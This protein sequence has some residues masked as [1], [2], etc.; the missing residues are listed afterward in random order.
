MSESKAMRAQILDAALA[1]V[2]TRGYDG[3]S[4]ADVA[5]A[6]GIRKPSVH[7]HFPTKGDLALALVER[8]RDDCRALMDA[9]PPG[10]TVRDRLEAYADLFRA[11]LRDGRMCLCGM[12]AAGFATQ[13]EPLRLAVA[14]ALEEHESRLAALLADGQAAGSIRRDAAPRDQA[15]ALVAGLEGALML[16]R[17]HGDPDRFDA[18]ARLLIAGL[19]P[20]R[21]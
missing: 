3:F 2:Q 10:A 14:G 8:F 7:H 21:A 16:A 1:L 13:P 12:L 4:Y 6:V 15:R 5:E 9:A 20:P 18:A 19:E 11:T 17:L